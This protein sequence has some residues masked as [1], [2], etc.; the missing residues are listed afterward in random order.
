M[1]GVCASGFGSCCVFYTTVCGG[2]IAYNTTYIRC[3]KHLSIKNS[4]SRF[5]NQEPWFPILVHNGSDVHLE[6]PKSQ[7][8]RLSHKEGFQKKFNFPTKYFR[9]DF[10]VLTL[11]TPAT[12][13]LCSSTDYFHVSNIRSVSIKTWLISINII[14]IWQGTN[15]AIDTDR[16]VEIDQD[17]DHGT[18][19]LFISTL[20]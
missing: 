7:R 9:L 13:G 16:Q 18:S 3:Q 2:E 4:E 8:G 15:A 19:V 10:D 12:S 14:L 20:L 11:A 17:Y 1:A 6:V 5:L